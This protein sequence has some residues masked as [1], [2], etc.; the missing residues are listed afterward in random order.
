MEY[1]W[2]FN[3]IC[4][5]F[6]SNYIVERT[7]VSAGREG[8]KYTDVFEEVE[9]H[10]WTDLNTAVCRGEFGFIQFTSCQHDDGYIDGR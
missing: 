3:G 1:M 10:D 2:N 4:I 5:S 6:G 7:V 8:E 9:Q